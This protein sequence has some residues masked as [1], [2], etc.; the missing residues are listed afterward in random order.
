M[1]HLPQRIAVPLANASGVPGEA[2]PVGLSTACHP[3]A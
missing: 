1:H 3:V 2:F